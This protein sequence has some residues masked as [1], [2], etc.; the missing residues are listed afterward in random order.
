MLRCVVKYVSQPHRRLGQLFVDD[1]E[2]LLQVAI[3]DLVA[4]G[5][6]RDGF[7][8][9]PMGLQRPVG[10][11]ATFP[12]VPVGRLEDFSPWLIQRHRIRL[13]PVDHIPIPQAV[14][15]GPATHELDA[16][17]VPTAIIGD[18]MERLVDIGG[19]MPEPAERF[20]ADGTG[21]RGVLE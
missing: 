16:D 10:R 17:I 15:V 11:P 20:L 18:H 19:Q 4:G 13:R 3:I 9:H 7:R 8:R 14:E 21:L 5:T 2:R 6:Q 1:R 12:G